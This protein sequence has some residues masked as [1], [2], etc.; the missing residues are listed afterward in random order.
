MR[1]LFETGIKHIICRPVPCYKTDENRKCKKFVK[2]GLF[3]D[4][5]KYSYDLNIGFYNGIVTNQNA[6]ELN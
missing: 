6:R 1:S 4:A 5:C 3:Y 2:K